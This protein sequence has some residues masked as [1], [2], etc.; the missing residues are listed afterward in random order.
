MPSDVEFHVVS[1]TSLNSD[2]KYFGKKLWS[3]KLAHSQPLQNA[4]IIKIYFSQIFAKYY[5]SVQEQHTPNRQIF[6]VSAINSL[7]FNTPN[8]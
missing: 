2:Q 1:E 8:I 3:L 4:K 6:A 7:L 5:Y